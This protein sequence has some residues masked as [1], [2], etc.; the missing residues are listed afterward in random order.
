[1]FQTLLL[2]VDLSSEASWAHA[3]PA[4]LK[5]ANPDTVMHVIA[6]VPDFGLSVVGSY[7]DQGFEQRALREIGQK[8][9]AWV[10]ENVP[11]WVDVHPHVLHGRVYDRI[12]E[13]A[14]RLRA[15]T[16]VMASHTP[17]LAD[18]LLGPNAARVVRHARCSVL[19]VRGPQP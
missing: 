3:L 19:V 10:R 14:D 6:V 9:T 7:F 5:L 16:I 2:P 8:L 18:Y 11:D 15:D 17:A 13:A 4:A 1:M 12:L